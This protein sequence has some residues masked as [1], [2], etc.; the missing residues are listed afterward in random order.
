MK[1]PFKKEKIYCI[2]LDRC[3]SIEEYLLVYLKWLYPTYYENGRLQCNSY[4]N[5]SVSDLYNLVHTTYPSTSFKKFMKILAKVLEKNEG[6]LARCKDIKK[7]VV[8]A[9]IPTWYY[10]NYYEEFPFLAC[11]KDGKKFDDNLSDKYL[12]NALK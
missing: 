4:C 1:L 9:E 12:L 2:K 3:K 10:D 11:Y 7:I 8:F 5:R 6:G